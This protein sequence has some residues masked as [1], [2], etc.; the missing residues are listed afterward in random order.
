MESEP[1]WQ[2]VTSWSSW[3]W[4]TVSL[5]AV[6]SNLRS[7][8]SEFD[9]PQKSVTLA[10]L[11]VVVIYSNS[12][13][14]STITFH[15][16]LTANCDRRKKSSCGGGGQFVVEEA[17]NISITEMIDFGQRWGGECPQCYSW[18]LLKSR[19]MMITVIIMISCSEVVV[20]L[21]RKTKDTVITVIRIFLKLE[22]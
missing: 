2:A 9:C 17:A 21:K 7:L 19:L 5:S 15:L 13:I 22:M 10:S 8:G 4:S 20:G 3:S 16:L 6:Y 12:L 14:I 11:K 18:Q 1:E